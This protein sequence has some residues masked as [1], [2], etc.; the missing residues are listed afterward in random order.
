MFEGRDDVIS[1]AKTYLENDSTVEY[2]FFPISDNPS[3][4][5]SYTVSGYHADTPITIKA[6]AIHEADSRIH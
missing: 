6:E 3:M 5:Q 1:E 2:R 4:F